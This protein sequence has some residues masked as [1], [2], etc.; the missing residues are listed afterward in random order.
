MP[1]LYVVEGVESRNA[2]RDKMI[3]E[4][5]RRDKMAQ[6]LEK[7]LKKLDPRL[8]VVFVDPEA[9]CLD[10]E[11]KAPGVIPARWHVVVRTPLKQDDA[12]FPIMGPNM[13]YADPSSKV[14]EDMKG[15]DLWRKG[16]LQELETRRRREAERKQRAAETESE[17][18]VDEMKSAYEAAKRMPGDSGLTKNASRK[19]KLIIPDEAA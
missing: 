7:E 13:E 4:W 10:P 8:E 17:Q 15:A 6:A 3:A 18:R 12:W 19:G 16:A 14:V 1:K 9:A 11:F 5:S 2:R